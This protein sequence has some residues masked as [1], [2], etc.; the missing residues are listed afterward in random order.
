MRDA[1]LS[2]STSKGNSRNAAYVGYSPLLFFWNSYCHNSNNVLWIKFKIRRYIKLWIWNNSFYRLAQ[3]RERGIQAKLRD[4]YTP[5]K[6]PEEQPSAIDVSM[7]TVAPI[8]VVLAAGYVTGIFAL[9]IERCVHGNILKCRPR[10]IVRRWRQTEYWRLLY[11][12]ST[13]Y[14]LTSIHM[15]FIILLW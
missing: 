1:F 6:E 11:K 13:H 15:L 9:L 14:N 10:R 7:V 4:E 5:L 3:I 8:F 12:N 2:R